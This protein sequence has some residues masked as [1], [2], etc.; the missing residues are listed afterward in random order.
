MR[1]SR[2]VRVLARYAGRR[3][4]TKARR[5]RGIN[6]PVGTEQPTS[7]FA[8]P[9]QP[10]D[11]KQALNL[12]W[13]FKLQGLTWSFVA[14]KQSRVEAERMAK[15]LARKEQDGLDSSSQ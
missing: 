5:L 4:P 2:A 8:L 15:E 13:G 10:V 7:V 9:A 11:A 3:G 1:T 12:C 6:G 14:S